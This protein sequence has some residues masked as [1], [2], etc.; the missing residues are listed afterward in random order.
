MVR[1]LLAGALSLLLLS[2]AGAQAGPGARIR[3]RISVEN[4]PTHF[5]AQVARTFAD[6]VAARLGDRV[7]VEFYDGARLFRDTDVIGAVSRGAVE[8]ALP[9]IWQFDRMVPDT[10]ALMLPSAYGLSIEQARRLADG[11]LGAALNARIE[12]GTRGK[13]LGRWLDLGHAH[14]FS[15][16]RRLRGIDDFRGKRVRVAG[17]RG[18]EERIRTL[19]A[20]PV[21]IPS[22][23]LDSY[24]RRRLVDGIL[25]TYETVDSAGMDSAGIAAVYEDAEYYPFYVPIA[26]E[27]F[28]NGLD[29]DI[30]REIQ[31]AWED[32]LPAARETALRAQEAAK[33]RLAGR[34][35]RI[36][37]PS[38]AERAA[39]RD[40][41][42]RTE[43]DAARRLGVSGE[44][45][46][47]LREETRGAGP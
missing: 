22:P 3:I 39:V 40:S 2:T 42:L 20:V 8:I 12:A 24:L 18:N 34:G 9:G 46:A 21:S 14:L 23:D 45:L 4:P 36:R 6:R 16:D 29:P 27:A 25:T 41:L 43:E 26:G 47:L 44:I 7:S 32:L 5:Q 28:W 13:V 15:L 31:A 19:G 37:V 10:A 1:R 33:A 17:G 30:R 35:L 11:P 38:K